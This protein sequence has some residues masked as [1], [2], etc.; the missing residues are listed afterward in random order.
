[1]GYSLMVEC[2]SNMHEALDL[3]PSTTKKFCKHLEKLNMF[4]N[5]FA[6]IYIHTHT[7]KHIYFLDA[8][9]FYL[10]IAS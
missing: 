5:A 2:L 3:I 1:M 6:Y 10:Q 4:H 7:D 9:Y 8:V